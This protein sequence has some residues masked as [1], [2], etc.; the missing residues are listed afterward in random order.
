MVDG[1]HVRRCRGICRH[2]ARI[3]GG[4]FNLLCNNWYLNGYTV[5][6]L[7]SPLLNASLDNLCK[8]ENREKLRSAS[9]ATAILVC[10][11]WFQELYGVRDFTPRMA[12]MGRMSFMALI[13]IYLAGKCLRLFGMPRCISRHRILATAG[14]LLL[15][16]VLGSYISP[17][18]I[19]YTMILFVAFEQIRVRDAGRK[20]IKFTVPSIFPIY[21]IHTNSIGFEFI[22]RCCNYI[23][24][25]GFARYVAYIVCAFS[26]FVICFIFDIPRRMVSLCGKHIMR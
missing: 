15:N 6:V 7:L 3:G 13:Y 14:C 26:V 2:Q 8:H 24:G 20:I 1:G 5:L 17:I 25:L 16:P 19:L 23:V 18:T 10:W 4:Y 21:L 22:D 12:G 9:I 11:S